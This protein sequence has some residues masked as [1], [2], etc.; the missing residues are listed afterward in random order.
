MAAMKVPLPSTE[1]DLRVPRP[2]RDHRRE[3]QGLHPAVDRARHRRLASRQGLA[4][5]ALG[6]ISRRPAP[7]AGTV[8]LIGGAAN[9]ARRKFHCP[10]RGCGPS[11]P[12]TSACRGAGAAA[13]CRS[14]R[15]PISGPMNLAAAVATPAFGLFG[16]KPVLSYS[17]FIHPIVPAGGPGPDGM[18]GSRPRRCSSGRALSVPAKASGSHNGIN[19]VIARSEA[20]KQSNPVTPRWIA[21]LRSQ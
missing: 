3:I 8:F 21:S 12:A 13:P 9:G 18:R 16:L 5:R 14:F 11:T 15:W 6:R 4:G 2:S 7:S 20:T 1:P 10:E 19:T 17:K